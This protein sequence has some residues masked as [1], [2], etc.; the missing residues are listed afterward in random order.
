ML[1]SRVSNDRPGP[2][3]S[4]TRLDLPPAHRGVPSGFPVPSN[5]CNLNT[6]PRTLVPFIFYASGGIAFWKFAIPQSPFSCPFRPHISCAHVSP[7][8]EPR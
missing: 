2:W 8:D 3:K 7:A 1:A 5:H 6:Y 4:S